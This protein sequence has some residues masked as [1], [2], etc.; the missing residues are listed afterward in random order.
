MSVDNIKRVRPM[1]KTIFASYY[2]SDNIL[3][4]ENMSAMKVFIAEEK[5]KSRI[6]DLIYYRLYNRFLKPFFFDESHELQKYPE[7]VELYRKQYKHGFA[8]M[9]NCCL[10]IETIASFLGGTNKTEKGK[11]VELYIKVFEKAKD[12]GNDLE[13]FVD[14][15]IY[16]AM[17]CGLLHQGETY[18]NFIIRR[19]GDILYSDD[20]TI[21]ATKFAKALRLFLQSYREELKSEKWDSELWDNCRT[22]IR[23]IIANSSE[24][25]GK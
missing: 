13:K 2:E 16:G 12:Y 18:D 6:A 22:K 9:A 19:S 1:N 24:K 10:L 5:N 11:A 8:M 3:Y 14:K 7:L 21:N 25:I 15:K 17:R 23:H 4:E 20:K